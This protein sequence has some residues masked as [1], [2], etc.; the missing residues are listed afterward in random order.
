ME[1]AHPTPSNQ[2]IKRCAIHR[3]LD[4]MCGKACQDDDYKLG[5]LRYSKRRQPSVYK[6]QNLIVQDRRGDYE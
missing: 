3:H 4:N 2:R 6:P 1:P 5:P